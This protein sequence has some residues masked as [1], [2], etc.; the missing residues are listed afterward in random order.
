MNL[1]AHLAH[2]SMIP[3]S[4]ET[5]LINR[6]FESLFVRQNM[7]FK[8]LAF[9]NRCKRDTT[10]LFKILHFL[11]KYY[12]HVDFFDKTSALK[13]DC[14]RQESNFWF[15]CVQYLPIHVQMLHHLHMRLAHNYY[16]ITHAYNAANTHVQ[17]SGQ[18]R[19][20]SD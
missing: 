8:L 19:R 2:K 12:I 7:I 20:Q 11:H 18:M 4:S 16:A 14:L 13:S 15:Q 1:G 6:T 9:V 3:G 5:F 10:N 17:G